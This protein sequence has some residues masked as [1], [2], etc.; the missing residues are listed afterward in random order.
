MTCERFLE[1]AKAS[2]LLSAG[3]VQALIAKGRELH[4]ALIADS[5]KVG[6]LVDFAVDGGLLTGW[7]C[8]KLMEGRFKGFFL[9]RYK[10]LNCLPG[11]QSSTKYLAVD[12]ESQESVEILV[13]P[14]EGHVH[15]TVMRK[16]GLVED[17]VVA[18][19]RYPVPQQ[20]SGRF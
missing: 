8:S 12:T 18:I 20:W 4:T 19:G 3:E 5:D 2:G 17:S 16:G 7:Q 9:G 14:I 1:L 13:T 11:T 6:R 15:F 10:L